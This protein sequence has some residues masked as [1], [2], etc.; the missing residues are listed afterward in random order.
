MS[1]RNRRED[2]FHG[3]SEHARCNAGG[4]PVQFRHELNH[5]ETRKGDPFW[6]RCTALL[7]LPIHGGLDPIHGFGP[8]HGGVD[9]QWFGG[10]GRPKQRPPLDRQTHTLAAGGI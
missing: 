6:G 7:V 1:R 4:A 2:D 8:I 5:G 10:F 3:D 9:S